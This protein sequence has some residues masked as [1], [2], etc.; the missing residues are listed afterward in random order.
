[1]LSKIK[2]DHLVSKHT[3]PVAAPSCSCYQKSEWPLN[4]KYL[5]KSLVYKAAI[6]QPPS[7]INKYYYRTCEITFKER[8]N[9]N[10]TTF[11]NKSK[12]KTVKLSKHIWELKGNSIQYQ[13][14]WDT[15]S[16]A[17]P[18]NGGTRKCD[19]CMTEK[20][21][22]AKAEPSSLLDTR[23]EFIF[24]CRHMNKF[25]LKCNKISQW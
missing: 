14:S 17:W 8:Y 10:T 16:R 20:L 25:T 19:L 13:I 24:K 4:I 9:N 21:M 5:S 7:Q 2:S 18:C 15:A 22:I 6:L 1:M 23:D 12:K 11:S 3:N